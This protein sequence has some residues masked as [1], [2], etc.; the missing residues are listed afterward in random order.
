MGAARAHDH[1]PARARAAVAAIVLL[2]AAAAPV[3]AL[4]L[5]PGSNQGIPQNLEAVEG[6]NVLTE[7]VGA[8]AV[9]PT[10]IV[11]DTGSAGR[12]AGRRDAGCEAA[13]DPRAAARSRGRRG[14][15]RHGAAVRRPDA[16]GT[17]ISA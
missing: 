16:A 9:A 13:S 10:D 3:L 5:G 17:S 1:A 2:L 11:V 14:R 12:R 6:N 4:Q 7:A 8:G 15:R